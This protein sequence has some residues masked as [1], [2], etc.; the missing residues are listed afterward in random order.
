MSI[1][2]I[3]LTS[4]VKHQL[5][6]VSVGEQD[7]VRSDIASFRQYALE[8]AGIA[9]PAVR[10]TEQRATSGGLDMLARLVPAESASWNA[11]PDGTARLFN[12]RV[13]HTIEIEIS[14]DGAIGWIPSATTL[15]LNDPETVLL[16]A[17]NPEVLL[18][19]LH[20]LALQA[21]RQLLDVELAE[22]TRAAGAF[23][24]AYLPPAGARSLQGVVA[25]PLW[26]A[27]PGQQTALAEL[28]VVAMRLTLTV[29]DGDGP[30]SVEFVYE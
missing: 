5:P 13:A 19:D 24:S 17:P 10:T 29:V 8:P 12:N 9:P 6:V 20:L 4:C 26:S 3:L 25:F 11:W 18:N 28:H 30:R 27:E 21:E 23:R 2:C 22:R 1:T 16:A 7:R 14:G 15:E